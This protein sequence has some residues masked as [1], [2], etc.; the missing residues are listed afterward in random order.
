MSNLHRTR[1]AACFLALSCF[2]PLLAVEG[3]PAST[4]E[5]SADELAQNRTTLDR[6]RREEPKR[7]ARL[8]HDLRQFMTLP[9]DRQAQLR[10]LD[11][12]AHEDGP[13]SAF[14][15]LQAATRYA[16]W[17][18]RL[19]PKDQKRIEQAPNRDLRIALIRDMREWEWIQR[20]PL[21]LQEQIV[22]A[23]GENRGNLI[24]KIR[25]D[26][27]DRRAQWRVVI[28]HWDDFVRNNPMPKSLDELPKQVQ[29][30]VVQVLLP[31]LSDE[32]RKRLEE[33]EGRW[34]DYPRLLVEMADT[35]P[36]RVLGPRG[37]RYF[38]EL[39]LEMYSA[40]PFGL[41]KN[42][43]NALRQA[44]G[45]WPDFMIALAEWAEKNKGKKGKAIV[46]PPKMFPCQPAHFAK[47]I[48]SFINGR[49][50]PRL[51]KEDQ[52]TL[53]EA[54]GKWPRYPQL[55]LELGRKYKVEF[56]GTILSAQ[57]GWWD[58]YRGSLL[59]DSDKRPGS[60]DGPPMPR[61]KQ[62]ESGP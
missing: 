46:F 57:R 27:R 26:E 44:A 28:R 36:V 4:P 2:L 3:P 14:R 17:E 50:F 45:K 61:K 37:P 42:P 21:S 24:A 9:A 38:S 6:Y 62:L 29:N 13:S 10:Q 22:K 56:P 23:E 48:Q 49:L 7:L 58:S 35:H 11:A 19:P 5:P 34:P 47:N 1:L 59:L 32:E 52:K 39:P 41:T 53:V 16:D 40:L 20:L 54:E 31:M 55:V 60:A 25:H 33:A 12:Q 15:L 43:P 30:F 8:Q 18:D 51:S